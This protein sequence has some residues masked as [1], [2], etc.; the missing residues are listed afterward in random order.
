MKHTKKSL[1]ELVHCWGEDRE[2]ALTE[3]FAERDALLAILNDCAD[4]LQDEIWNSGE[5]DDHPYVSLVKTARAAIAK[6][7]GVKE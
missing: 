4:C 7:G 2:T 1:M 5:P 3:V 6:A